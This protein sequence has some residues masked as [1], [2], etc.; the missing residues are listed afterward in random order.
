MY[1]RIQTISLLLIVSSTVIRASSIKTITKLYCSKC[2]DPLYTMRTF[3]R[4]CT[5]QDPTIINATEFTFFGAK[6]ESVEVLSLHA[7]RKIE[8][9]PILVFQ[10]FPNL[11][12]YA[13]SECSIKE[14][15][16]ENFERLKKLAL[17]IL[18]SNKI[19]KLRSNTF[20]RL[21][22]LKW[23]DLGKQKFI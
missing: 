4:C 16:K 5:V 14:I 13:A 20:E 11:V 19:Q 10:K 18:S 9:L 2:S 23:I 22:G 3:R 8:Y 17:L 21:T 15:S 1:L 12:R 6:D 7:N